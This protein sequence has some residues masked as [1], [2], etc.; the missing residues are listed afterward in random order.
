M[1]AWISPVAWISHVAE[2]VSQQQLEYGMQFQQWQRMVAV[3]L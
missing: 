2:S 3:V 1:L